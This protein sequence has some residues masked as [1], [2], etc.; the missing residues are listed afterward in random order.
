VRLLRF[1]TFAWSLRHFV[2][3]ALAVLGIV[4]SRR[5]NFETYTYEEG[6]TAERFT[7]ALVDAA[8]RGV[9]VN[10]VMDAMLNDEVNVAVMNRELGTQLAGSFEHDLQAARRITLEDWRGR[11]IFDRTR[12]RF[13]RLFREIF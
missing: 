3:V 6:D 13:W 2:L 4:A 8:T 9:E 1:G 12:E 5:I 11:P 7:T 10:L